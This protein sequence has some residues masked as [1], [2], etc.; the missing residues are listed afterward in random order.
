MIV[1]AAGWPG[2]PWLHF[3]GGLGTMEARR[4]HFHFIRSRTTIPK[5]KEEQEQEEEEEEEEKREIER[6][7]TIS[8]AANSTAYFQSNPGH[9]LSF[10]SFISCCC[11]CCCL[12]LLF[13]PENK[14]T[15]STGSTSSQSWLGKT[16]RST[17]TRPP[18]PFPW[19]RRFQSVQID[20]ETAVTVDH[21]Q[22][23]EGR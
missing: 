17:S 20:P 12:I 11:Y 15:R 3:S 6:I 13:Q 5:L 21:I 23:T 1:G 19:P 10:L 9:F 2:R 8:N 14:S 18:L 22:L 4:H 16:N 7:E